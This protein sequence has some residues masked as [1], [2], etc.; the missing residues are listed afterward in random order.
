M[1]NNKRRTPEAIAADLFQALQ[2]FGELF[3]A[4][5]EL[6]TRFDRVQGFITELHEANPRYQAKFGESRPFG[7]EV[8]DEMMRFL[9]SQYLGGR[10]WFDTPLVAVVERL[11]A[12]IGVPGN[13]LNRD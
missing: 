3:T 10:W 9:V 4:D 1:G 2:H 13:P 11:L 12:Q 5:G 8:K 7:H 6:Q